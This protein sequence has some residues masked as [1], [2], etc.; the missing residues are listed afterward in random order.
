MQNKKSLLQRLLFLYVAFFV[1]LI[2]GFAHEILPNFTRGLTEGGEMG[3]DIA[4]NWVSGVP[5]MIY[6]LDNIRIAAGPENAV[7][8]PARTPD[9]KIDTQIRKLGMTVEQEAP[10]LSIFALAFRSIGGSEWIYASIMLCSCAYLAIIVLMFLII[11]SL[12]RSIR[13]ERMLESRNVWF[14]RIIGLLTIATELTGDLVDRTMNL[15]A[16]QLLA[17]SDYIVDTTFHISYS[18]IVMGVL[19]LFAAEVFAICRNLSEEQRLTI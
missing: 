8:V 7:S 5:R 15:R 10:G 12:R 14:L 1:V 13:E 9:L 18:T 11:R 17:E 3:N 4:K 16:A 2:A 19:I 6:M